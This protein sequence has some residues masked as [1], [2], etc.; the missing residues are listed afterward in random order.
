MTKAVGIAEE[1]LAVNVVV[2]EEAQGRGSEKLSVVFPREF[3]GTKKGVDHHVLGSHRGLVQIHLPV[4]EATAHQVVL[5]GVDALLVDNQ[6]VIHH[7]EHV[8]DA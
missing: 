5:N 3:L 7:V 6:L 8:D 1:R 4:H 2:E